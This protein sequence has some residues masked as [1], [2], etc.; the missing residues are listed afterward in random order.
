[1][2]FPNYNSPKEELDRKEY[3]KRW[4]SAADAIFP[5]AVRATVLVILV[6]QV[7]NFIFATDRTA[8]ILAWLVADCAVVLAA[9]WAAW[10]YARSKAN[11]S[12]RLIWK[13]LYKRPWSFVPRQ[14]EDKR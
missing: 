8:A 9:I 3:G 4:D 11:D 14:P 13:E 1:M 7:I 5:I 12:R 6:L 2:T 10:L